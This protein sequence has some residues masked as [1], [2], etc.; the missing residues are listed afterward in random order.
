MYCSWG[1]GSITRF[2]LS[3]FLIGITFASECSFS[4]FLMTDRLVTLILGEVEFWTIGLMIRGFNQEKLM[5]LFISV[6]DFLK[7]IDEDY[8]PSFVSVKW[9]YCQYI[10]MLPYDEMIPEFLRSTIIFSCKINLA[11]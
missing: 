3:S 2:F 5:P 10:A 8:L 6:C 1:G 9:I 11:S 7:K 4:D